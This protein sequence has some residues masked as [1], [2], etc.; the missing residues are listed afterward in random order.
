MRT[1]LFRATRAAIDQEGGAIAWL[2]TF[3]RPARLGVVAFAAALD[4]HFL[5]RLAAPLAPLGVALLLVAANAWQA[6]RPLQEPR[7]PRRW[8]VVP[9]GAALLVPFGAALLVPF[10]AA[11]LPSPG[12]ASAAFGPAQAWAC[13]ASGL[14]QGVGLA[15]LVRLL[16]RGACAGDPAALS[17][18]AA[19]AML[20][21][22]GLLV[23]CPIA[24]PVHL[25]AGHA[26]VPLALVAGT[27]VSRRF[28]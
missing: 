21:V 11:L 14:A 1:R 7:G 12:L 18:A 6:L 24:A 13:F 9:I 4:L 19:G 15:L 8:I 2:R 28:G 10:A 17:A 25:L 5:H 22:A 27:W 23:S 3:S 16:D 26:T 20:G